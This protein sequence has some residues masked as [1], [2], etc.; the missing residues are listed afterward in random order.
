MEACLQ[1]C[2]YFYPFI[3]YIKGLLYKDA[4]DS[5]NQILSRLAKN[6]GNPT[7]IRTDTSIVGSQSRWSGQ[8]TTT[9]RDQV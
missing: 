1:K 8:L 3:F 6:G 7:I 4:E 5:L 2:W 9:Y